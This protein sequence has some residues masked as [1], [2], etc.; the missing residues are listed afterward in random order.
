MSLPK[1]II[2]DIDGTLAERV[3]RSPYDWSKVGE[4]RVKKPIRDIVN[5]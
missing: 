2:V 1:A 4:D 5:T 3:N